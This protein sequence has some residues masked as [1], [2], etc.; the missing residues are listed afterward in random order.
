METLQVMNYQNGLWVEAS[1]S[2]KSGVET[3]RCIT[4]AVWLCGPTLRYVVASYGKELC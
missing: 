1:P 3:T 4:A 2:E